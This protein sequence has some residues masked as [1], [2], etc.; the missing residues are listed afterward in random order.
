MNNIVTTNPVAVGDRVEFE[1]MEDGT[2]VIKKVQERTNYIIRRSTSF[3]REAHLLAANIDQVL[4]MVGLKEPATPR[5]FIDRFLLTAEAYHIPGII[6]INKTDIFNRKEEAELKEF[7][8]TYSL[9]EYECI[10][11]SL[12]SLQNIDRVSDRM[13]GK[14]S[15]LAGISGVGKSSLLNTIK[16]EL[17]LKTMEISDFHKTGKHA[18][19]FSEVFKLDDTTFV[20][21]SPGIRGFGLIDMEKSEIGLYFPEIFRISKN[22]K[23]YNCTHLHEPGCAVIKAV[24]QGEIGM[25]RFNSYVNIMTGEESKYR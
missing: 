4:L 13:K 17:N 7:M 16:P 2:G 12:I 10:P 18:T 22:C 3:H 6:L 9:A 8:T 20:I 11:M 21:D 23:F 15:L 25:S 24:Q 5:E 1:K 19:T 14:M